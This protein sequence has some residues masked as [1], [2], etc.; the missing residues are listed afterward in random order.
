M[1]TLKKQGGGRSRP[2]EEIERMLRAIHRTAEIIREH[3]ETLPSRDHIL[4]LG[5]DG[6]ISMAKEAIEMLEKLKAT[7]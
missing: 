2:V 1:K 5:T 7:A 3:L 6:I 4:T